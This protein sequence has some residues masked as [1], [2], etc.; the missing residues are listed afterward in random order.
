MI[1]SCLGSGKI[2]FLVQ[3]QPSVTIMNT[4]LNSSTTA[5]LFRMPKRLK[6]GYLKDKINRC[7]VEV[8]DEKKTAVKPHCIRELKRHVYGKQQTW[9][10]RTWP[11]F[12]LTCRFPVHYFYTNFSS[13]R[14]VL[15]SFF[16][17]IFHFE[18]FST[19]IWL[20]P[21]AI[22]LKRDSKYLCCLCN[23]W[24]SGRILFYSVSWWRVLSFIH[25][26]H[27]QTAQPLDLYL[28][29]SENDVFP[30]KPLCVVF[31]SKTTSL[32]RQILNVLSLRV[33]QQ[34]KKMNFLKLILD[35]CYEA[36]HL[37]LDSLTG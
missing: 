10:C 9:I 14:I 13:F 1:D 4:G 31:F 11:S 15:D 33:S 6:L 3:W 34:L 36:I 32:C 18:N 16:L 24:S 37:A 8:T 28:F 5:D 20:L 23:L 30:Q 26:L 35:C 29:M 7:V 19:C 17:L 21:F 22:C 12:R 25:M 2:H 27:W